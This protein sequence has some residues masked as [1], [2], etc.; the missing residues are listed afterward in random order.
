MNLIF[1][2][3]VQMEYDNLQ[4]G[5]DSINHKR[6]YSNIVQKMVNNGVDLNNKKQV[7]DFFGNLLNKQN[8]DTSKKMRKISKHWNLVS[9]DVESRLNKLFGEKI[10]LGKITAYGSLNS[11][12]G[13]NII[14][15]YFYVYI[16]EK[17]PN[18]ALIHELLH[19]YTHKIVLKQFIK[20][21]I[22]KED[23]NDFKEALTFLINTD[24]ADLV[25]G[26]FD[27][28]YPKQK[29][30]RDY[31]ISKWPDCKDVRNLANLTIKNYFKA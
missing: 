22:S 5:I 24:F 27:T 28:G 12:C 20:N 23:F 13:Y 9:K 18:I 30:L 17:N 10:N 31:L 26:S 29:K 15:K 19:F 25:P 2:Y 1:K 3:K 8:V 11:R 7:I 4:R 6:K 16:F 21:K 14:K